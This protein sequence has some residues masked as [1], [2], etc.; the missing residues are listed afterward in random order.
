MRMRQGTLKH[1][2][3]VPSPP[4]GCFTGAGSFGSVFTASLLRW[5]SLPRDSAGTLNL[6][7]PE[8]CMALIGVWATPYPAKIGTLVSPAPTYDIDNIGTYP[9][10]KIFQMVQ[11]P[12][13]CTDITLNQ[14]GIIN[15]NTNGGEHATPHTAARAWLPS[16][17]RHDLP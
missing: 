1:A 10:L 16:A 6:M 5:I 11:L 3:C 7:P 8:A 15:C 2:L 12:S 13:A 14:Q 4:S 17:R 9:E